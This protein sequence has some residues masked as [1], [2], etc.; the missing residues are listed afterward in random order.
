MESGTCTT[1][2]TARHYKPSVPIK[3]VRGSEGEMTCDASCGWMGISVTASRVPLFACAV[4]SR[5]LRSPAGPERQTNGTCGW[6]WLAGS[7]D[8]RTAVLAAAPAVHPVYSSLVCQSVAEVVRRVVVDLL[9]PR[10][11]RVMPRCI[12]SACH[13]GMAVGTRSSGD[14][15]RARFVE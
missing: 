8:G 2:V 4:P 3:V 6:D 13:D 11:F 10:L 7:A 12:F 1:K 15:F 9:F 14:R 5:P